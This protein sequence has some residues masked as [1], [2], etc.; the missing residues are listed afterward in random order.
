MG[1]SAVMAAKYLDVRQIIAVDIVDS[2]LELAKELGA[3]HTVNSLKVPHKNVLTAIRSLTENNEGP[4]FAVDCTGVVSVIHDVIEVVASAGTAA[5]VGIVAGGSRLYI[6]A[7]P[8]IMGNKKLVGIIGGASNPQV[9]IPELVFMHREGC[10][11]VEKLGRLYPAEKIE[12]AVRDMQDG[13]V[14]FLVCSCGGCELT[15]WIGCE[16]CF[17]MVVKVHLTVC[18]ACVIHGAIAG[19]SFGKL[20]NLSFARANLKGCYSIDISNTLMTAKLS[21]YR[22]KV[23]LRYSATGFCGLNRQQNYKSFRNGY[24]HSEVCSRPG[25]CC[26]SQRRSSSSTIRRCLPH[27]IRHVERWHRIPS[28]R[29]HF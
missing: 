14:G 1:L 23:H 9:T 15:R 22:A 3:T 29:S 12:E 2:K 20:F 18:R 7:I 11:P 13:K 5:L 8:F 6:D 26:Y 21:L 4:N 17:A 27:K 19:E 16:A 10:F 24:S 28:K 25:V